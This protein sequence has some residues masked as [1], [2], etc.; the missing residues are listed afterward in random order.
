M[1]HSQGS[2][3]ITL[4][5]A[6]TAL[7]SLAVITSEAAP[8]AAQFRTDLKA[9]KAVITKKMEYSAFV[10]AIDNML[11]YP[12][13]QM[14]QMFNC[15]ILVPRNKALYALGIKTLTNTSA[16]TLIGRYNV[17]S[18]MYSGAQLTA[19]AAGKKLPTKLA[20][21]PLQRYQSVA[22]TVGAAETVL[23]GP[24]GSA[25]AKVGSVTIPDMYKGNLLIAHG[26]SAFFKPIGA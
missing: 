25:V 14:P 20:G 5:L 8:T 12:D 7:L 26:F 17:L 19:L 22:P 13:S 10:R 18:R 2:A 11:K 24:P 15:T 3:T 4:L 23:V 6:V 9:L 21:Q 1:A 16:M